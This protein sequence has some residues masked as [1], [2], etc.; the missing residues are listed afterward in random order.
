[1]SVRALSLSALFVFWAG[2]AQP[3]S[4]PLSCATGAVNPPVRAEGITETLGDILLICSG[5]SPGSMITLNLAIFLN[6]GITNRISTTNA[7]DVSLTVDT[8]SGPVPATVPGLLQS[9]N[10]VSFNG[11]TFTVPA[12]GAVNLRVSN[13]RG[14]VSQVGAGFQ[15]I[16]AVLSVNG[17][18][19]ALISNATQLSVGIPARGLLTSLASTVIR[20]T[21]SPLPSVINFSNL[22]TGGTRF[23]STR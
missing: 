17:V 7:T 16:Q 8:G 20:C 13:L 19:A 9:S 15:P 10:A 11:I 1:M 14:N 3:Q 6:V 18:P 22:L 5:G 2:V 21:G 23:V 12:S 4:T